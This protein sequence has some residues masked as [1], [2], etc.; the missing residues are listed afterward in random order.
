MATTRGSSAVA[1]GICARLQR[2]PERLRKC[3]REVWWVAGQK[4]REETLLAAH[5]ASMIAL[6]RDRYVTPGSRGQKKGHFERQHCGKVKRA[7]PV[8]TS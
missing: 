8:L 3:D 2:V 4:W 6:E 1:M 5:D 7:Y